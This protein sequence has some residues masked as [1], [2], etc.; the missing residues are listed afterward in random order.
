[1]DR[2]ELLA[3]SCSPIFR[4]IEINELNKL[5]LQHN[6]EIKNFRRNEIVWHQG[7]PLHKL[8]IVIDGRLKAQMLSDDG[9]TINMEEFSANTPV[10]V[11]ILLSEDQL[12]P[13]TLYALTD[14]EIFFLPKDMLLKCCMS[15]RTILENTMAIMSRQ[16]KFLSGK[17]KYLQLNIK[18]KIAATLITQSEKNNTSKFRMD[19]TKEELAREMGVTRPSLS[20]EFTNLAKLG[21]I[22]QNRDFIE[23]LNMDRLKNY[24]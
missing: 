11:P 24:K 14:S 19:S 15:D 22:R 7:T 12:L 21:I 5:L 4:G 9:K 10:A 6:P 17:I 23:I 1:M 16:V 3:I 20:R 8:I 13:V 2:R 18:Q